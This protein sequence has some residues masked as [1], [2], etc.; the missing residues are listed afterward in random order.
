MTDQKQQ[1]PAPDEAGQRGGQ[2]TPQG[3]NAAGPSNAHGAP[4]PA[5]PGNGGP[6]DAPVS[7]EAVHPAADPE[8]KARALLEKS[9]EGPSAEGDAGPLAAGPQQGSGG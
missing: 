5:S 9:R 7:P 3:F 6:E 4:S 1:P 2:P 8:G